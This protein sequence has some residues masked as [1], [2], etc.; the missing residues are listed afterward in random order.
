MEKSDQEYIDL[1]MNIIETNGCILY[2]REEVDL[3]LDDNIYLAEG[4]FA[5]DKSKV[6]HL[7]IDVVVNCAKGTSRLH[8]DT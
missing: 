8:V 4:D 7:G 1:L 3:V 5:K 2:P 6:A